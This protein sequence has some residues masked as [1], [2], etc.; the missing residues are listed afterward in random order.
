[1]DFLS[2]QRLGPETEEP[3]WIAVQ[4]LSKRPWFSRL[5]TCQEAVT[6]K[7][8]VFLCGKDFCYH[9]DLL[10]A[11]YLAEAAQGHRSLG[12]A[13]TELTRVQ[14]SRYSSGKSV[15]LLDLLL[16]TSQGNHDCALPHDRIYALLALQD[17]QQRCR[18]PV[19]YSRSTQSLYTEVARI[20]ISNTRNLR[21]LHRRRF[22]A[23]EGLP[24]WVPDWNCENNDLSIDAG[25]VNFSS[26]KKR[27]HIFR[28]IVSCVPSYQR[29]HC[30]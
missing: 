14:R 15:P 20:I 17:R 12:M 18:V 9:D 26:S 29:Q 6:S 27:M 4:D 11:F 30:R 1:M 7:D 3:Q 10:R 28:N 19:D 22:G 24:S 8:V 5:R 23:L 16:E 25:R 21:P 13:N 2:P